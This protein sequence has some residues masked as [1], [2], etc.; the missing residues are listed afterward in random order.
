ML[1]LVGTDGTRLYS[2]LLEPGKYVIGRRQECD[3]YIPS[4][5]ISRNHAEIEV[6]AGGEINLCDL[7]SHNGTTVNDKRIS[8]RVS[9]KEGDNL[10]FG[11]TE[12]KLATVNESGEDTPTLVRAKLSEAEPVKSVF[13][14][15]NEAL[16]PLPAKVSESS[17][18]LPTI[19]EMARMLTRSDPRE[20][21]LEKSL[22]LV[23][24]VIPAERLAVLF[25][26]EDQAEVFTGATLLPSGKDPGEFR[27]SQ[28][29]VKEIMT[30][31]N[32]LVIGNPK[33]DPRFAAQ[34]SIIMSELK[35]AVAV[36]LFDE[37]AVL[38]ILYADTTNPL[39][40][41][42]DDHLRVMAAFGNIIASR[43]QNYALLDVR[44]QREIMEAELKRASGIQK[45]LLV[46]RPPQ[47]SGFEIESFQEQSR[48]VG[49]DLY[50]MTVLPDGRMLFLAADVSGKGMGAA[51]LMSNILAAF[52][53]MYETSDFDLV[54][55]VEKV[56]L[57]LYRYSDPGH[58]ATLF[59]GLVEPD[60]NTV[61]YINAGHNPP[62]VVRTDGSLERLEPSGVMIGAFDF[63]T[64]QEQK[65]ELAKNE[66]IFIFT[67]GVTEAERD[68]KQ[69][70]DVRM[71]KLVAANRGLPPGEIVGRLMEDINGFMGDAPR[72]DDITVLIL[73]RA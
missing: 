1:K 6:T 73:K 50:D 19:F 41:Y 58:F 2:W 36:P 64:W 26:S 13:L 34:Q 31:R 53:I 20:V 38:G 59:I 40:R 62:L 39:H 46:S 14:N 4:K 35:S 56:S 15:I 7:G 66:L 48:S 71:E 57:Q 72:S 11:D 33:D 68:N 61:R 32:A 18:I 10:K 47:I 12:F 9:I 29:I 63:G 45:Q 3:F 22:A 44:R 27:L 49:G 8:G 17:K 52:R 24:E 69:Y 67:D 21:M 60:G 54:K 42:G 28:T 5:T 37:G 65:V 16:K 25:V 55:V 70:G 51:L 43:L 23:A 30:D